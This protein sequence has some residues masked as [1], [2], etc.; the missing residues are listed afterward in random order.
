LV[1]LLK[2]EPVELRDTIAEED[3][4]PVATFVPVGRAVVEDVTVCIRLVIEVGD[5]KLVLEAS[6]DSDSIAVL[7]GDTVIKADRVPTSDDF[8]DCVSDEEGVELELWPTTDRLAAPLAEPDDEAKTPDSVGC[9]VCLP[10]CVAKVAE[11]SAE[12]E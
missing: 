12:S 9:N 10:V 1:P 2:R 4:T 5:A 6:A 7:D 3:S 8:G 11:D